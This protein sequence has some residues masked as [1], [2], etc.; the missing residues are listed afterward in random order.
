MRARVCV[1]VCVRA[2]VCEDFYDS[3]GTEAFVTKLAFSLGIPWSRIRVVSVV[4]GR[5]RR[6]S[7]GEG[8]P[9]LAYVSRLNKLLLELSA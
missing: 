2:C 9:T 3:G 5:R 7:W 6:L 8:L 4:A 1:C